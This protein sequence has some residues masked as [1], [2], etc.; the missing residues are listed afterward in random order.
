MADNIWYEHGIDDWQFIDEKDDDKLP[1]LLTG[2]AKDYSQTT[3]NFERYTI[4]YCALNAI[5]RLGYNYRPKPEQYCAEMYR[6]YM[7][8]RNFYLLEKEVN[9]LFED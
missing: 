9:K 6:L 2:W 5:R 7:K 4:D 1:E 8:T 3:D